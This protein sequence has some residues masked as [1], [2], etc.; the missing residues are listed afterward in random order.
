MKL[1]VAIYAN[2]SNKGETIEEQIY[3]CRTFAIKQGW[4]TFDIYADENW[5]DVRTDRPEISFLKV[6]ASARYFDIVLCEHSDRITPNVWEL[7]DFLV[8]LNKIGLRLWSVQEG[9]LDDLR[10][11]LQET[12]PDLGDTSGP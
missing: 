10:I 12:L 4:Q 8:S 3:I 1:R 5:R 11:W 7:R 9:P 6:E 2:S